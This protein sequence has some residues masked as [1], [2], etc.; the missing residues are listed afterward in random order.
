MKMLLV[1]FAL[2]S[3][4]IGARSSKP[5]NL[6]VQPA[7]PVFVSYELRCRGGGL[8]FAS[9]QGQYLPTGEQMMNMT[10]DFT[11]GT[12]GAANA[13]SALSPGQCS[14]VDR[15]FRQGEPTQVRF[16]IVYFGQTAQARHGSTIDRSATAAE[17]YPDAQNLPQY[18]SDS[19]HYWSFF[20]YNTNQGYLQATGNKLHKP[21]RRLDPNAQPR[22]PVH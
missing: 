19:S 22:F 11:A 2:V 3:I 21:L 13:A 5:A 18:L 12:K 4:G 7:S 6:G 9:T 14:W 20:V 8:R 10:M 1:V 16:E 15:G 17:H